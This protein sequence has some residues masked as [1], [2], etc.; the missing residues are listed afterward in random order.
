MERLVNNVGKNVRN[1]D[2]DGNCLFKSIADQLGDPFGDICFAKL[3]ELG[4]EWMVLHKDE[5]L[6][7]VVCWGGRDQSAEFDIQISE[8]RNNTSWKYSSNLM[9]IAMSALTKRPIHVYTYDT[10]NG[11]LFTAKEAHKSLTQDEKDGVPI[12]LVR[13]GDKHFNSAIEG[14]EVSRKRKTRSS[15]SNLIEGLTPEAFLEAFLETF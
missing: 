10:T 4:V 3:R 6:Q 1:I 5:L 14:S 8:L 9:L 12:F 2:L 15:S 13:K 7:F 11:K